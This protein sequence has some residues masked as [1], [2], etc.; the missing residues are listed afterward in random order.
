V[1]IGYV[2]LGIILG[3]IAAGAALISGQS[4]LFA[5]VV[6]AACGSLSMV[7]A[8]ASVLVFAGSKPRRPV[9]A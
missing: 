3:S 4:F 2:I 1:I 7:V 6:Y 9:E 5:L 8:A